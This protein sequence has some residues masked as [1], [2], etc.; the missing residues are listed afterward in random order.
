MDLGRA[1]GTCHCPPLP[2]LDG[3]GSAPLSSTNHLVTSELLQPFHL[4][5][6]SPRCWAQTVFLR[7]PLLQ[8]IDYGIM[9][10]SQIP[11]LKLHFLFYSV[12]HF[13][14]QAAVLG[15]APHD[16]FSHQ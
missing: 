2:G 12:P 7:W 16:E 5:Y 10:L 9:C 3:V 15:R 11:G 1:V 6:F 4:S 8:I 13:S 14:N